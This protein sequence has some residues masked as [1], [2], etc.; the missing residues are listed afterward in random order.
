MS[1]QHNNVNIAASS[2]DRDRMLRLIALH[3]LATGEKLTI[4]SLLTI[5]LDQYIAGTEDAA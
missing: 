1:P 4:K 5:L 2:S 3:Q